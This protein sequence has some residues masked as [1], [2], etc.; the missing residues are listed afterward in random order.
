A[1][2]IV[3]LPVLYGLGLGPACW[4]VKWHILPFEAA[5]FAYRPLVRLVVESP[6]SV[7]RLVQRYCEG[8]PPPGYAVWTFREQALFRMEMKIQSEEMKRDLKKR[9]SLSIPP[10][11]LP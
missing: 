11:A 4:L 10:S 6:E 2:A 1:V 7:Q 8:P 3:L 5:D 9:T